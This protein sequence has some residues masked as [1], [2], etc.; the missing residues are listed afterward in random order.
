M[1]LLKYLKSQRLMCISTCSS[2]PWASIVFYTIDED[3]RMYFVS[4]PES[5][6]CT[7]ISNNSNVACAVFDSRQKAAKK[8]IGVQI[9]GIASEVKDH[10][11]IKRALKMW[12][13]SNP[14]LEK[15]INFD[16][17]KKVSIESRV[18]RIEPKLIKFFNEK[19]Y[20][21]EGSRIFEF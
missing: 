11:E 16:A 17:I 3:M 20:G 4:E 12:N 6:H 5:R 7:D 1:E 19:L 9:Q 18:Y 14:G 2:A 21:D 8:K 13:M 10:K 15:L